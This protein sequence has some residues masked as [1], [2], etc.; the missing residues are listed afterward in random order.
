[1]LPCCLPNRVAAFAQERN[2]WRPGDRVL[3]AVSGGQDSVALLALLS[4]LAPSHFLKLDAVHVNHGMRG[5]ESEEDARFVAR[6]CEQLAVPFHQERI[7]VG[8]L[9][10]GRSLQ[11]V[12]REARYAAFE[13]VGTALEVDRIALGHTLDDQ[14][15]TL[16]MWMLRG[17]G[18]R[19]LAGIP[20]SRKPWFIRPLLAVSRMELRAYLQDQGLAFRDDSSNA[21]LRYL[22]NRVRQNV[23]P[24]LKQVNP[25]LVEV[26]ARQ[27]EILGEEDRCLEAWTAEKLARLVQVSGKDLLVDRAGLL[28]LPLAMQRRAVRALLR[29]ITGSVKGPS[30][31]AVEGI[32]DRVLRARSGSALTLSGVH[33]E[34]E[35]DRLRF[36][37]GKIQKSEASW[38]RLPMKVPSGV[39]WRLTGQVI[40]CHLVSGRDWAVLPRGRESPARVAL[41]ADRFSL[42][43]LVVR[44]RLPGDAFQPYGLG[45]RRKKLQDFFTDLKLS[46][47]NRGRVP[48]LVAPEGI[49]WVG[50]YR[51]DHR[52]A[53]TPASS[54]ILLVELKDRITEGGA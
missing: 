31:R 37:S 27:A 43:H 28:A 40:E 11:E 25:S 30:F 23:M 7:N 4:V 39:D 16:I 47:Q 12:A 2:L 35:Y 51:V 33:V 20:V 52:F 6:I 5:E 32:L 45:G 44:T 19:G 1:M 14:A 34:R 21:K 54:Q 3:A 38:V 53:A 9:V 50:G 15:E 42:D 17:S 41:D 46:R 36:S 49:L 10:A 13:R 18:T 22:R 24:A 29:R 8:E 48:L 26:L